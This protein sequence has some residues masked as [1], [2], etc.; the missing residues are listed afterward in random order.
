MYEY[1]VLLRFPTVDSVFDAV[2]EIVADL[3]LAELARICGTASSCE[4][5]LRILYDADQRLPA[6]E[7]VRQLC[8]TA[9]RQLRNEAA[10]IAKHS[11]YRSNPLRSH[12]VQHCEP[13]G[14]YVPTIR[15]RQLIPVA[16][17]R[18]G[19]PL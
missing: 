15:P 3:S 14:P 16:P 6:Q 10:I 18:Y 8:L 7:R 17:S 9:R 13:P 2:R 4:E 1:E 19:L 5:F 11:E 12:A